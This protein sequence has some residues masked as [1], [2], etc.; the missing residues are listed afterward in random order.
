MKS[1]LSLF[2]ILLL[3]VCASSAKPSD[4]LR[5]VTHQRTTVV[6]DPAKGFKLYKEWGV[7]PKSDVPIRKI[8]MKVKFACPDSM[9]CADWD[10]MDR[11]SIGRTGGVN[12][13]VQDYEIG[14]MLTPYGGAFGKD[15]NFEWELDVTDF[16]LL[17]RD[18]VEVEYRH[19]GY[20]PNTD[21]GWAIT[22]QFEVIK[23]KPAN[24][25]ISITKI[26]DSSYRYGDSAKP[27]EEVLKPVSF[28]AASDA[29]FARLRMVQ[30]GHGMDEPD[31]CGEFCNKVREIRYDGN[32]IDTRSIWKECGDNPLYPQ[33]G[34][35]VIDR[36]NWCPGNLMQPDVYDL[37]V[38]PGGKHVIDARM[39][40]YISTKPSADEVISAYLIQYKEV[41]AQNDAAL[42]D[43]L[44]PSLKPIYSR[45]NPA[46]ANAQIRVRNL[47]ANVITSLDIVYGTSGSASERYN[48]KGEIASG[49][50]T[51]ITLP[52]TISP[53]HGVHIFKAELLKTNGR[54]DSYRN[55]NVLTTAFQS[56]PSLTDT[57]VFHLQTNNQPEHNSYTLKNAAHRIVK[58]RTRGSLKANTV[59]RD[60]LVL[61]AG[62]YTLALADTAGD[63]L[64]LWFNA[65]GGRGLARLENAKGQMVKAFE[66]DSGSGWEYNFTVGTVPDMVDANQ[67]AI[68][69]YPTRTKDKTTL[70]Y[71]GNQEADVLVQLVADPGGK[72]LE[73]HKYTKLKQGI[74]TFNLEHYVKG[75]FYMK[76]FVDGEQK[77]NKRIRFRE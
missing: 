50:S 58:E 27:L 2:T 34:T 41:K 20:E 57:L 12:G 6:T 39:Q 71:F 67:V 72:I 16:A 70:D 22:V 55:D 52:G 8:M 19:T 37:K 23:G 69:L 76:V 56:A 10:Y 61:E 21:R 42:E 33:A 48:W 24:K 63:G 36:A 38:K 18:S 64:E 28:V 53:G 45:Q 29:S 73:E 51:I 14:R 49:K 44:S 9:R 13:K 25:P 46:S 40:K 26:Y 66:S 11:I 3:N 43:I 1:I 32:L 59:Y 35:W 5:I 15:W 31:G 4:T 74:F 60:T 62:A 77:F 7:F 17:L 75:R 54:S 68:G 47:G 30:T 65:R